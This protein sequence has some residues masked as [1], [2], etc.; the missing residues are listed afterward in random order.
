M[1]LIYNQ[2][3]LS[4]NNDYISYDITDESNVHIGTAEG[5][6]NKY[7][8]FVSI[9]KIFNPEFYNMGLG[10]QFFKKVFD[11]INIHHPISVIK[12]SWHKGG[13]FKDFKN[14]MSSNLLIFKQN[15]QKFT[16]TPSAVSTPTGRWAAK[17][18]F[19]N[20]EIITN[21]DDEVIVHFT[22]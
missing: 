11:F 8:D 9:I 12:A 5:S 14:G 3:F 21:T 22:R 6:G 18:G 19:T 1:K 4:K 7:G 10:L 17:I 16:P 15:L 13:E 20:C 2:T